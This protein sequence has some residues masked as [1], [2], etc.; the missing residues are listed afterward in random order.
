VIE[1]RY[2]DGEP[3]TYALSVFRGA[4]GGVVAGLRERAFM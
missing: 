4:Q 2:A 1:V 3:D